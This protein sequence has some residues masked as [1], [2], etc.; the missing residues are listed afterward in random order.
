MRRKGF[1]LVSCS[2]EREDGA[3]EISG[4]SRNLDRWEIEGNSSK[5]HS[6]VQPG[7]A[8]ICLKIEFRF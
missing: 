5:G 2:E 8:S 7:M 3:F 6:I 4:Y 1:V